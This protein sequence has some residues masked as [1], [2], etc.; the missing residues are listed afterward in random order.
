MQTHP[1]S[2]WTL[3]LRS[4]AIVAMASLAGCASRS[5]VE[6]PPAPLALEA[7]M[8][9]WHVIAHVPNFAE[10]GHVA[11]TVT[12]TP[13]ADGRIDVLYSAREGFDE[14]V[15]T[16]RAVAEVEPGSGN[17]LWKIRYYRVIPTR[18]R[19]LEVAPDGAWALLQYPERDLAW[20]FARSP[21]VSG[22]QYRELEGRIAAHGVNTDKLRRVPQVR[23]QVGRL[24]FAPPR[25]P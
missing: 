12:Y 19:I 18:L 20:I 22:A 15:E 13:G 9:R 3:A 10:R 4:L 5:P 11:S 24:G 8:G 25:R 7:L 6:A 2:R 16:R 1:P 17:R 21:D 14:P 23:A